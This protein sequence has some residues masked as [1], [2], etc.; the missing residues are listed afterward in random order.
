LPGK[1]YREE[2]MGKKKGKLRG[3]VRNNP[4]LLFKGKKIKIKICVG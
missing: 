3:R 4:F 1:I 2:G